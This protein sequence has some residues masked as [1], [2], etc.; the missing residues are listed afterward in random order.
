MVIGII[1][2]LVALLIPAV[3]KVRD[4]AKELKTQST[5]TA[6]SAGLE[7]YRNATGEP[8]PPSRSDNKNNPIWIVSPY[9]RGASGTPIDV[10][11]TGA[12]MLVYA[13][14]GADLQGTAGFKDVSR[15]Q[16]ANSPGFWN[17]LDDFP[18]CSGGVSHGLY[19]L[20]NCPGGGG[21]LE[22]LHRRFGPFLDIN[23]TDITNM[24][25]YA[26]DVLLPKNNYSQSVPVPTGSV[27]SD[28]DDYLQQ[29]F[30]L[31]GFGY[32]ILYYKANVGASAMMVDWTDDR[33]P[34]IYDPI[35]N[36]L[37]TGM[38]VDGD[39][40]APNGGMDLGAGKNHPLRI[41][42]AP[43]VDP[44]VHIWSNASWQGTFA[45]VIWDRKVTARN[46][47]VNKDSYL[48]I[49]PGEDAL[50]GTDDDLTNFNQ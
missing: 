28:P 30:I 6:I 49:S 27:S 21:D 12:N 24:R 22:P 8:Y 48:L 7:A 34:G 3:S 2:I 20:N 45:N 13:L 38:I 40:Y 15:P 11:V 29:P 36:A 33:K 39:D 46:V 50:W 37:Y 44:N 35:D 26:E 4:A 47:P 19:A 9:S 41:A 5:F 10:A 16:D 14:A 31:D 18:D 1:G 43:N 17:N 32:P 42:K 23:K 25:D